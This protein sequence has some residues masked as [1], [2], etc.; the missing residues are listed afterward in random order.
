[1]SLRA[2]NLGLYYVSSKLI[3][4]LTLVAYVLTGNYLTAE[5]VFV[6]MALYQNVRLLMTIFFPW[7]ISF[8]AETKV[9]LKRIEVSKTAE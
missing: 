6:A 3:I 9:S 5:K 8:L 2:L 1:M 7:G 4:F